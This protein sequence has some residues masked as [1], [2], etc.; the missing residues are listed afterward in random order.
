[1]SRS[2]AATDS[3]ILR[4]AARKGIS[5]ITLPA[6]EGWLSQIVPL[7]AAHLSRM[8]QRGSLDRVG[9]GRYVILPAGASNAG[10]LSSLPLLLAAALPEE[11][12]Y[13]GYLSAL[14]SHAL[15]DEDADAI[16]V[17]IRGA[18]LPRL[19]ELGG[20]P[21]KM[22]RITVERKWFGAARER[23]QGRTFYYRSD[24]ERTLIDTLDQPRLCGAPDIW[25]RAWERAFRED[26]VDV[27]QLLDYAT[28]MGASVTARAGFWL[29]EIGRVRE[30]RIAFRAAGAPLKGV[31]LLDSSAA[32]GDS[33]WK[34]DRES[35]LIVNIPER[36]ITGWLEYGK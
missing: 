13:L 11:R 19:S 26:R 9:Q 5:T 7:P 34:R 30:A 35:G 18:A 33:R 32:F 24:L 28:R 17:A 36:A 1:M 25:V 21:V 23:A 8:R 31:R 22:H 2:T 29:R 27:T 10:Q 15:T 3:A 20:R 12:Y 6:D 14:Q 16:Y 4:I